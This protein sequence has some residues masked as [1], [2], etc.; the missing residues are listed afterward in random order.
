MIISHAD[1]FLTVPE[2]FGYAQ[3][4]CVVFFWLLVSTYTFSSEKV[5]AHYS[6]F[7]EKGEKS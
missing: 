4:G 5:L 6:R 7:K 1:Y 2:L 3:A